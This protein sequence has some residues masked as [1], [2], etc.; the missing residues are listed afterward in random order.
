M[1]SIGNFKIEW[2]KL[3]VVV[4]CTTSNDIMRLYE[5]RAGVNTLFDV[6][7]LCCA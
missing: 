3:F 1:I 6:F 5:G 4:V 7:L 2:E